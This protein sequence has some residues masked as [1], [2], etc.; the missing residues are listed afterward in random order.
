MKI[1]FILLNNH[2]KPT[3]L[4]SVNSEFSLR[5]NGSF[6]RCDNDSYVFCAVLGPALYSITVQFLPNFSFIIH[7]IR[8]LC[9]II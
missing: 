7:T 4:H 1:Y 9:Q 2:I 8:M 5:I 6:D 3:K